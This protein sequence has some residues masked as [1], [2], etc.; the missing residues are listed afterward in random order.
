MIAHHAPMCLESFFKLAT[1]YVPIFLRLFALV[2]NAS[3][4]YKNPMLLLLLKRALK[5]AF[6][7]E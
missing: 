7:V 2:V 3:Q 1:I 6:C 5:T 4:E